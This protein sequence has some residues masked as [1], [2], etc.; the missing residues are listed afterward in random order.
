MVGRF[1]LGILLTA[2]TCDAVLVLFLLVIRV[3]REVRDLLK[4]GKEET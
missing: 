4:E 3:F 1:I 2:V